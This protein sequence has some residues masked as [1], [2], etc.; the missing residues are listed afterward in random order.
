LNTAPNIFNGLESE[1]EGESSEGTSGGAEVVEVK[2]EESEGEGGFV[3]GPN[4]KEVQ[5]QI[6]KDYLKQ[7]LGSAVD[8]LV[9]LIILK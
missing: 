7:S 9:K 4:N 2:S 3:L 5:V 1:G 6:L 8:A